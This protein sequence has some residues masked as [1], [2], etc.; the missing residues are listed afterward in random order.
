MPNKKSAMKRLRQDTKKHEMNKAVLSELRTLTKKARLSIADNDKAGANEN[1]KT[2]ESK[3]TRAAQK[4]IV[5][6][7]NASRRISRLRTQMS[8]I[9]A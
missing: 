4:N 2:L 8:K 6:K 9:E 5:K 1:L 7:N 3:L